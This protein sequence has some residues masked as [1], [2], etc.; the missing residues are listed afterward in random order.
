MRG[1]GGGRRP[2]CTS[3]RFYRRRGWAVGGGGRGG[4]RPAHVRDVP[5]RGAAD[6]GPAHAPPHAPPRDDVG[7][8]PSAA[9]AFCACRSTLR[10]A[11]LYCRCIASV[12]CAAAAASRPPLAAHTSVVSSACVRAAH[13]YTVVA[14][15]TA[16]VFFLYIFLLFFFLVALP[17]RRDRRLLVLYNSFYCNWPA[18]FPRIFF[19]YRLSYREETTLK[20]TIKT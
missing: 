3:S 15:R 18:V 7:V 17:N 2:C 5:P 12:L 10:R 9:C 16:C 19:F 6:G 13:P 14:G 4:V 1:G 8:R 20:I 11:Y